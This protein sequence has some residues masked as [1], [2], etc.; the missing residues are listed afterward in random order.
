MVIIF[1]LIFGL[2][3]ID[4]GKSR[5]VGKTIHSNLF[6]CDYVLNT[7]TMKAHKPDC[8]YAHT[9]DD[10]NIEQ[11]HGTAEELQDKGY[12]ACKHCLAW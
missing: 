10:V 9:I 1:L 2:F 4:I 8:P 3:W 6:Q 11:Y 5:N 12:T 7:R